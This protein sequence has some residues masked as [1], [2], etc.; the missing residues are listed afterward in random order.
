MGNDGSNKNKDYSY[1]IIVYLFK[2]LLCLG[3]ASEDRVLGFI[4]GRFAP[5]LFGLI[6]L[7]S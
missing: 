4:L 7:A 2:I 5:D 6:L 3:C 1:Y